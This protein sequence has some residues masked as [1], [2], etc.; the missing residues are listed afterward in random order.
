MGGIYLAG[1]REEEGTAS[2][3]SVIRREGV[4]LFERAC[5]LVLAAGFCRCKV[6]TT[7]SVLHYVRACLHVAA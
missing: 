3:A 7:V 4:W 6:I 5:A 1:G 2:S